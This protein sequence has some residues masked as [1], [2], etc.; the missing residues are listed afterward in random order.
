M[1]NTPKKKYLDL[2]FYSFLTY[3]ALTAIY[4][5]RFIFAEIR[6]TS[7]H[8]IGNFYQAALFHAKYIANLNFTFW[9]FFDHSNTAFYHLAQGFYN[10]PALIEGLIYNFL[11]FF[12]SENFFRVFHSYFV[13]FFF[14][15]VRTFGII[16]ILE[17]YKAQKFVYLPSILFIN[18]LISS[19]ISLGYELGWLLS[20]TP[21]LIYY[22][23]KFLKTNNIVPLV[24]FLIFYVFIFSQIPLISLSYFFPLFHFIVTMYFIVMLYNYFFKKSYFQLHYKNFLTVNL[25]FSYHYFLLFLS[26][27]VIIIFNISFFLIVDETSAL[28]GSILGRIHSKS[29]I[30]I[31][32]LLCGVSI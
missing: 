10:L 1:L 13:Q 14:I 18:I 12:K 23:I 17:I 30:E 21:I 28:T 5:E 11:S 2:I 3:L 31:R 32:L 16:L 4:P 26:L 22:L 29:A 8:T 15:V 7:S 6:F 19:I 20:I 9:N 24:F 27:L 25:N